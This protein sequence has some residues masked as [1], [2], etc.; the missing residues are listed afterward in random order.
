MSHY[1]T[2]GACGAD[3]DV[4]ALDCPKC[5]A[6]VERDAQIQGAVWAIESRLSDLPLMTPAEV[7]DMAIRLVDAGRGAK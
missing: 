5:A 3:A 4:N 7:W 1:V 6:R 2:C